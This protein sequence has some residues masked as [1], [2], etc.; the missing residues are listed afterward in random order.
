MAAMK[1]DTRRVFEYIK[2][3]NN[4]DITAADVA[5]ALD[6]D[7]RKVDGIFTSALQRKKLGE[8][9]PAERENP[10]GT[11]DRIKLLHLTE[12]GMEFDPD[13]QVE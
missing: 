12:A 13:L 9:I 6:L 10:D 1:P 4:E 3:H 2:A 11:H 8:R 7:K 5:E